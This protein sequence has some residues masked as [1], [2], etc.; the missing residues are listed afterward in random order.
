MTAH[1]KL[2][3]ELKSR[4]TDA[5][6]FTTG[7][8]LIPAKLANGKFAWVVSCFEDSTFYDGEYVAVS[9]NWT[10]EITELAGEEDNDE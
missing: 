10:D 2:K 4:P 3:S 7:A 6:V 8:Q 9:E 1:E 5:Q